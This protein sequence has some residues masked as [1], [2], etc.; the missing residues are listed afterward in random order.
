MRRG[1]SVQVKMP[2]GALNRRTNMTTKQNLAKG[3]MAVLSDLM[4]GHNV[5]L[6]DGDVLLCVNDVRGD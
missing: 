5:G 2:E 1:R 6:V 3:S 4:L